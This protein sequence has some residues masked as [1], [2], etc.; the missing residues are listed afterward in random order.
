MNGF[1]QHGQ[2]RLRASGRSFFQDNEAN[3]KN[4]VATKVCL[5][6]LMAT[7]V[8]G[9]CAHDDIELADVRG[10][11]SF[12][13]LPAAAELLFEPLGADSRTS[14]RPSTAYTDSDGRFDAVF[15][16]SRRGAA[17]GRHRVTIKVFW[18]QKTADATNTSADPV[19][20]AYVTR[21]VVP[22]KNTF[23]FALAY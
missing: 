1:R 16:P 13:G 5:V 8:F 9:G 23:Y 4:F 6:C 2:T 21:N 7:F 12:H 19:K 14:G 17:V 10:V 22:G 18:T 11:V 20:I 15:S 3:R